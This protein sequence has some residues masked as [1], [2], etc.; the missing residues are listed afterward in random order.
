LIGTGSRIGAGV[1]SEFVGAEDC[2]VSRSA[3]G[4]GS[5]MFAAIV[6][7]PQ[8]GHRLCFTGS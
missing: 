7:A 4:A 3:T 2:L 5:A 1:A 8:S 6:S